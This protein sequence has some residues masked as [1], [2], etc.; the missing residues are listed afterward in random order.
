M[1][2]VTQGHSQLL[3]TYGPGAMLDLPDHAV[4]VSGLGDWDANA[5]RIIEEGRLTDLLRTIEDERRPEGVVPVLRTPPYDDEDKHGDRA[6]GIAVRV[7]PEWF[8][9][10]SEGEGGTERA[11]E[12]R[13]R[14]TRRRL[15]PFREL[16]ATSAGTLS[17]R[18]EGKKVAVNPIRFVAACSKGHLQD[19]D[20]RRLVHRDAD[21][22]CHRTLHWVERGVSSDPSDVSVR[23]ECGARVTLS[24]LYRPGFLGRCQAVSP[25]LTP[26]VVRDAAPCE[27]D[28]R[29][30][31]R[32][33]TNAYFP[34]VLTLI[35]LPEVGEALARAVETH[36]ARIE[37]LRALP[38]FVQFLKLDP[39]TAVDFRDHPDA[40]IMA[41][42]ERRGE[43]AA[44]GAG[45]PRI[46]EFDR[47]TADVDVIGHDG[48]GSR[49][50][51]TRLELAR[52][53]IPPRIAPLVSG[54]VQV[55]RLREVACLYG[56]TRL[57]P[58]PTALES[59]LDDIRLAV[60]GAPLSR[61]AGWFPATEQ[62]GEGV[63]LR[64]N[65]NVIKAW[66]DREEVRNHIEKLR[67]GERLEAQ[68]RHADPEHLGPAYWAIHTLSHALMAELAL[69]CGYPL[70]SLKERI[71][72]SK[73]AEAPR[74]A[75]LIYTATSGGQG[76]LGGLSQMAARVPE[77]L[78]RAVESDDALLQRPC[79]L[80]TQA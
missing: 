75:I 5:G 48:A 67:K 40:D 9:C 59:E 76:T 47:L 71:Y 77:L 26:R 73:P 32:S 57:E 66:S 68:R 52:L 30:L 13:L 17:F 21:A 6:P 61:G 10:D 7:F 62:F 78:D 15:V 60:D 69:E 64:L 74:H 70:S 11:D 29:L 39:V 46:D 79:V 14:E 55:H 34:Q 58:A 25:W 27:E 22:T 18:P 24:E 28:L 4:I 33:A 38:N 65:S 53:D 12:G 8:V 20:W 49:L 31:P 80:R 45:D 56:F 44:S 3:F 36:W 16:N 51:A 72:A 54:V 19:I 2:R 35:S 63:F 43:A 50:F 42:I 1:S 23:C 37:S 41:A